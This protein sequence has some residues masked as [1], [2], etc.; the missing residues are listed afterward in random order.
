MEPS[1]QEFKIPLRV[2]CL[3]SDKSESR[4]PPGLRAGPCGRQAPTAMLSDSYLLNYDDTFMA[5]GNQERANR[6]IDDY[7]DSISLSQR[8]EEASLGIRQS[9]R[10]DSVTLPTF[11]PSGRQ[12]RLNWCVKNRW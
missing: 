10:G 5:E 9:P 11:G 3:L 1:R 12:E 8:A 7:S 2:L 6:G 4:G